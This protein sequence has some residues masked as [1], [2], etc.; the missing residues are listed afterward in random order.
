MHL[1]TGSFIDIPSI[2]LF[3]LKNV[4]VPIDQNA[5]FLIN[6]CFNSYLYFF[7]EISL[8]KSFSTVT[9]KCFK[10]ISEYKI[11]YGYSR[12]E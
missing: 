3:I 6:Y 2:Y 1:S 4:L 10:S 12:L 11:P 8:G 5:I 9:L 7:L